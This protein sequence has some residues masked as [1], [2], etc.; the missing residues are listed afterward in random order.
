[1]ES[2]SVESVCMSKQR[3]SAAL[4]SPVKFSMWSSF[5]YHQER[6]SLLSFKKSS[7]SNY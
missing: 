1:M 5:N 2:T 3:L 6:F 7:L 4:P